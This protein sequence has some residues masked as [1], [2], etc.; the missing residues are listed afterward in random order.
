MDPNETGRNALQESH[1]VMELQL[2][3]KQLQSR[4]DRHALVIQVLK[5]M[6][7]AGDHAAEG[8]FLDRLEQASKQNV[9]TRTCP[10]CGKAMSP[11]H[12]ACIYCGDPR[13]AQ[14]L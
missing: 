3:V 11:K 2:A 7:L 9:D 10:K 8:D 6:L 4:L 13:P 14:L 1:Q 5:E 12:N